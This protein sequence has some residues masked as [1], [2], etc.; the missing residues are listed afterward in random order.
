MARLAEAYRKVRN[1]FRYLLSNLFD[2]D[3]SDAVPHDDLW[4]L[5]RYLLHQTAVLTQECRRAMEEYAFHR[6]YHRLYDF[7]AVRLSAFYLDVLKDRLYTSA[8]GSTGRRSA[9]TALWQISEVLVRLYAPIFTFTADEVWGYLPATTL[10]GEA[11]AISVHLANLP[12]VATWLSPDLEA[13]WDRLL[14]VR[15]AVL[16][17]LETARQ[18]KRIGTSLEAAVHLAAPE[19]DLALLQAVLPQLPALFITS[20][21][22]VE[23]ARDAVLTV[24]VEAARGSKCE[25][26]WNYSVHVGESAELPTVCERCVAALQARLTAG[27]D[28]ALGAVQA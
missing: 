4:E 25:R 18:E 20:Q 11:R 2:F 12:D 10:Q 26:C 8:P 21:V 13:R 5:D 16:G 6:A 1:T 9:Q 15:E 17:A 23:A 19:P 22:V 28:V 7:C 24:R 3:P 14:A 27:L